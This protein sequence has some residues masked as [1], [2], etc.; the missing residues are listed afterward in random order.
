M[1]ENPIVR[2]YFPSK[3]PLIHPITTLIIAEC[4]CG[5]NVYSGE[6]ATYFDEQWYCN[7]NCLAKHIGAIR[8]LAI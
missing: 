2:E 6:Q 4:T 5:E 3:M 8:R 7:N 1:L